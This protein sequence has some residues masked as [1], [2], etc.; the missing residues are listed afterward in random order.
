MVAIDTTLQNIF[1][2][3]FP[4]ELNNIVRQYL[5][6]VV[7]K[8][9]I[10]IFAYLCRRCY[11]HHECIEEIKNLSTQPKKIQMYTLQPSRNIFVRIQQ[12]LSDA[13]PCR[14]T[15]ATNI[16]NIRQTRFHTEKY[17]ANGRTYF[18][19]VFGIAL[20][21]SYFT[22]ATTDVAHYIFFKLLKKL[23]FL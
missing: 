18:Y 2:E 15:P 22:F 3:S 5:V 14:T 21:I 4:P 9:H 7:C 19:Q 6:C 16:L 23:L 17:Y 8:K 12:I 10:V 13:E 1:V 20:I 11:L